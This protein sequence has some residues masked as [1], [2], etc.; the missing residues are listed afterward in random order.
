VKN[1]GK[2]LYAG[3][4]VLSLA[5]LMSMSTPGEAAC[6][7]PVVCVGGGLLWECTVCFLKASDTFDF[8]VC[9]TPRG[10]RLTRGRLMIDTR[11]AALAG[12]RWGLEVTDPAFPT[13][14][15]LPLEQ[16]LRGERVCGNG[17][18]TEFSG[19]VTVLQPGGVEMAT[20]QLSQ[21]SDSGVRIFPAEANIR[22]QYTGAEMSNP[23]D[24]C[25]PEE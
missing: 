19:A 5:I 7:T 20:V 4:L 12:D 2:K 6:P 14:I 21:C 9:A 25:P 23:L 16:S 22:F 11:D 3:L 15:V 10:T 24:P 18:T 17:S 1:M 8:D 13:A